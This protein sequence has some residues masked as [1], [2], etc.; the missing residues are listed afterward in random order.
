MARS[1]IR[2]DSSTT[3]LLCLKLNIHESS[4]SLNHCSCVSTNIQ[5]ESP[6]PTE[7]N[8]EIVKSFDRGEIN[9]DFLLT[10]TFDTT[11][12]TQFP[13]DGHVLWTMMIEKNLTDLI[14]RSCDDQEF[15]VHRFVLNA[16]C[17]SIIAQVS[18]ELSTVMIS[19][20]SIDGETLQSILKYIYT[21]EIQF[22]F[23]PFS[24]VRLRNLFEAAN[25]YKLISFKQKLINKCLNSITE[26][27]VF[28]ILQ[29]ADDKN[30]HILKRR[31]FIFLCQQT[32]QVNQKI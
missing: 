25:R 31:L 30:L 5:R 29:L 16:T 2:P 28:D 14:L 26:D 21:D 13:I 22:D 20:E 6:I 4:S 32:P 27:N 12:K 9:E 24:I 19:L 23:T 18:S 10:K 17:P 1:K 3:I 8:D 7:N 15:H 11:L